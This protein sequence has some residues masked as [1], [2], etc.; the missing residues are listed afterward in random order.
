MSRKHDPPERNAPGPAVAH[1]PLTPHPPAAARKPL[2][3]SA[4]EEAVP[5][6]EMFA[7][8][9][10][11]KKDRK[12]DGWMDRRKGKEI[13]EEGKGQC[14]LDMGCGG[15]KEGTVLGGKEHK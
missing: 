9:N 5:T 8:L 6:F 1:H 15:W 7:L 12:K 14:N 2:T 10:K 13:G 11:G 4:L 3:P